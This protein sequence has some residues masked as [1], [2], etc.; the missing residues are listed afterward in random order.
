MSWLLS[1]LPD[2]CRWIP[3]PFG[4]FVIG[5]GLVIGIGIS[6]TSRIE[7]GRV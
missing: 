2:H 5:I 3:S 1:S 6:A 4:I 7:S